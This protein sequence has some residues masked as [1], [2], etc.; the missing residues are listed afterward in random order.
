MTSLMDSVKATELLPATDLSETHQGVAHYVKHLRKTDEDSQEFNVEQPSSTQVNLE[1]DAIPTNTLEFMATNQ[2]RQFTTFP[3][4]GNFKELAVTAQPNEA[5]SGALTPDGYKPLEC[6]LTDIQ[7]GGGNGR[8]LD[9]DETHGQPEKC[10]I[11]TMSNHTDKVSQLSGVEDTVPSSNGSSDAA[12][13][14]PELLDDNESRHHTGDDN[15]ISKSAKPGDQD[16]QNN[17]LP[18]EKNVCT[19]S[20][21]DV[22]NI[23]EFHILNEEQ[24]VDISSKSSVMHFI[25]EPMI[26]PNVSH[27][28]TEPVK[29]GNEA[30]AG[31]EDKK[32]DHLYLKNGGDNIRNAWHSQSSDRKT[33]QHSR[34]NIKAVHCLPKEA[35]ISEA[36]MSSEGSC[37]NAGF[38]LN[39]KVC[40]LPRDSKGRFVS[41]ARMNEEK[42]GEF[43]SDRWKQADS[44]KYR[45]PFKSSLN[46]PT[47]HNQTTFAIRA[48]FSD[49]RAGKST[50]TETCIPVCNRY[51]GGS[52]YFPRN[53]SFPSCSVSDTVAGKARSS[54]GDVRKLM[55]CREAP[56]SITILNDNVAPTS[57]NAMDLV[58]FCMPKRCSD[59]GY[60]GLPLDS[61]G[62]L[63]KHKSGALTGVREQY[64]FQNPETGNEGLLAEDSKRFTECKFVERINRAHSVTMV[65]KTIQESNGSAPSILQCPPQQNY[66]IQNKQAD[67]WNQETASRTNNIKHDKEGFSQSPSLGDQIPSQKLDSRNSQHNIPGSTIQTP[68]TSS[69]LPVFMH[70]TAEPVY[71]GNRIQ[72]KIAIEKT[73]PEAQ[74]LQKELPTTQPVMRLMGRNFTVGGENE[75]G[76]ALKEV[77]Q[78]KNK[79]TQISSEATWGAPSIKKSNPAGDYVRQAKSQFPLQEHGVDICQQPRGNSNISENPQ[80]NFEA[81]QSLETKTPSTSHST[82]NVRKLN[83]SVPPL[84]ENRFPTNYVPP[85]QYLSDQ[86]Y[87]KQIWNSIP[88]FCTPIANTLMSPASYLSSNTAI[89]Q[90]DRMPHKHVCKDITENTGKTELS[91]T[92]CCANSICFQNIPVHTRDQGRFFQNQIYIQNKDSSAG[93][94]VCQNPECSECEDTIRNGEG[95]SNSCS[96]PIQS[97]AGV[98]SLQ[99]PT[100]CSSSLPQWLLNAQKQKETNEAT[101]YQKG[102]PHAPMPCT[103]EMR[104]FT[105]QLPCMISSSGLSSDALPDVA[106]PLAQSSSYPTVSHTNW[107][108]PSLTASV[109]NSATLVQEKQSNSS[110]VFLESKKLR[111]FK[112]LYRNRSRLNQE[113]GGL[114][115]TVEIMSAESK[116]PDNPKTGM[117]G[118]NH[119]E[120]GGLPA[121]WVFQKH[122]ECEQGSLQKS[123]Q[124]PINQKQHKRKRAFLSETS[125]SSVTARY[126]NERELAQSAIFDIYNGAE[127]CRKKQKSVEFNIGMDRLDRGNTSNKKRTNDTLL[128]APLQS[129]P[130]PNRLKSGTFT[131]PKN[132]LLECQV[133]QSRV[134]SHCPNAESS[135]KL[136]ELMKLSGGAKHILK[137]PSQDANAKQSLPI[138]YTLPFV[139]TATEAR[140]GDLQAAYQYG[141]EQQ[142]QTRGPKFVRWMSRSNSSWLH[143]S[144]N[145]EGNLPH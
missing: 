49:P 3:S 48:P 2:P 130:P 39:Q 22:D 28:H 46:P 109:A 145:G 61:Q 29:S 11:T 79:E 139:E 86:C 90:G 38:N 110:T 20:T 98:Q 127:M 4:P 41:S 77:D 36:R 72:K 1:E 111:L 121:E 35:F 92:D 62:E 8:L 144:S 17:L 118:K 60:L 21:I 51:E 70:A 26:R 105:K 126:F 80:N 34:A 5:Q 101:S 133:Q 99:S 84:V 125:P 87:S 93:K 135:L 104:S 67:C 75:T 71:K 96:V 143:K 9:D 85:R 124:F 107:Q 24:K 53:M 58:K 106:F 19:S 108:T 136:A 7:Q 128:N 44:H 23:R 76:H 129:G 112:S 47:I 137:P 78:G 32:G 119:Q 115:D 142:G 27:K 83:S 57:E 134:G 74:S 116:C 69:N 25:D 122:Q 15:E 52:K 30:F 88:A 56:L 117:E 91:R 43:T 113:K 50:F 18:K 68:D 33:L 59:Y 102:Q 131:K 120:R 103:T 81:A 123:S 54:A 141:N 13:E 132:N 6:S 40:V 16:L 12:T 89:N 37:R 65:N 100:K 31:T 94:H 138:H 45:Q 82:D 66:S 140:E 95:A 55:V 73:Y 97:V 10:L 14:K 114:I 42:E 64:K 63:I